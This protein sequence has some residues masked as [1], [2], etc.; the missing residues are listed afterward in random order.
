MQY[1]TFAVVLFCI[2]VAGHLHLTR[3]TSRRCWAAWWSSAP[4]R[5]GTASSPRRSHGAGPW[6]C[7]SSR[8]MA[9]SDEKGWRWDAGDGDA[10]TGWGWGWL[11]HL[12]LTWQCQ[13]CRKWNLSHRP[14][15]AKP[16]FC[17]RDSKLFTLAHHVHTVPGQPIYST[18]VAVSSVHTHAQRGFGAETSP[19]FKLVVISELGEVMSPPTLRIMGSPETKWHQII[20]HCPQRLPRPVASDEVGNPIASKSWASKSAKHVLFQFQGIGY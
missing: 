16:C 14:A 10:K 3:W 12:I 5:S 1:N 4:A 13:D 2:F 15:W 11:I 18:C 7:G 19:I 6:R 9:P 17:K 20:R 8:R